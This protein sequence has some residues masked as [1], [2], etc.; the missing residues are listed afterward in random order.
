LLRALIS[1]KRVEWRE[2]M[3]EKMAKSCFFQK[4]V[5]VLQLILF[6]SGR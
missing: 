6:Q 1:Q 4:K 2:K 3:I 5:L